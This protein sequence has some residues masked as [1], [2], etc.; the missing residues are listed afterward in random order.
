[1]NKLEEKELNEVIGGGISGT[2]INALTN[3]A[4]F[5]Y[6]LGKALGSS[7]RRMGDGSYC[8]I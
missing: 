4:K 3:T 5:L 7:L 8:K 1:M 2:L 6:N